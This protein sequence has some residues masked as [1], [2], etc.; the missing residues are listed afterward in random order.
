MST[1]NTTT[2]QAVVLAGGEATRLRPYTDDRPK[3]LVQVAGKTIFERQVEWLAAGG[4]EHVVVACGYRADVFEEFVE[5]TA[6][7]LTVRIVREETKLGRG[8]GLKFG[9]SALPHPDEPWVGL[10]G[11]VLTADPVSA[12]MARHVDTGAAATVAVTQYK[13]PYG[14]LDISPD[15]AVQSFIEGPLLPYW[16]NAGIYVFDPATTALLPD[17]GDHEDTT[18]PQLAKENRLFAYQIGGWWRGIDTV[19]DMLEASKALA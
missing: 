18:F 6:L 7:P 15:N 14:V 12:V 5:Q 11:D 2:R 3:P 13:C 9:A 19:K 8:G 4:V 16:I 10:N 1:P 17:V